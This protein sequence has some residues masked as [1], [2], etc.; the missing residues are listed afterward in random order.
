MNNGPIPVMQFC[1]TSVR[2][3]AEE[4]ILTL[5][6]GF[7]RSQFRL[8][9]VCSPPVAD[10]VRDDLPQD[11]ELLPLFFPTPSHLA[12]ASQLRRWIQER[13]IQ[14]L[15]SHL[16]RSSLCASPVGWWCRVPFIVETPH[17]RESWRRGWKANNFTV[18]HIAGRFVDRYIAVSYANGRYLVHEK[19]LPERKVHVIQNGTDLS[20]F[21]PAHVPRAVMRAEFGIGVLDPVMLVAARLE[22][23]K[24]HSVLLNAMPE[25]LREFPNARLF[26][27][28]DG[29][30]HKEL[31]R[32]AQQLGLQ[33]NVR[34]LGFR[35]D[36][37]DWLAVC[38]FTI[39]PSFYEGLPLVAVESLAAGR[40]MVATAVDGTPE[41]IVNGRTGITVP[42]GDSTALAAAICSML[43][44]PELRRRLAEQG[45][46]YVLERFSQER[47]VRETS[48]FYL[49]ALGRRA[50]QVQRDEAPQVVAG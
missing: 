22:P 5:L 1:N 25:V 30:L 7:D 6:R 13:R 33:E 20:R 47:Q 49:E 46:E 35:S 26:C 23:Q 4:H 40:T 10:A 36:A 14:V 39:L 3:G 34:F 48:D 21:T 50:S 16:F 41:V 42:P 17:V 8:H 11:V 28:G 32:Q 9:L 12:G 18:D 43:R 31:E 27:L 29:V 37:A 45:R 24:G 38:D 15:H 2:A 19:G 44:S